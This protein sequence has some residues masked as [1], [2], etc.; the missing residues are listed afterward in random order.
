MLAVLR[1]ADAIYLESPAA[2]QAV[3][4]RLRGA[5]LLDRNN[6]LGEAHTGFYDVVFTLER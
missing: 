6:A 1:K 2:E 5:G 4:D 3:I